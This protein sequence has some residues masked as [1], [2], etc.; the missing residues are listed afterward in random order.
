MSIVAIEKNADM[1]SEARSF[2]ISLFLTE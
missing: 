2:F 1:Q